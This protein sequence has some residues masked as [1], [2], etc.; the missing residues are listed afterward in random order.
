MSTSE[1]SNG[2]CDS[3]FATV[4]N[5]FEQNFCV[6]QACSDG[7]LDRLSDRVFDRGAA[8]AIFVD[9]KLCVNLWGGFA[10]NLGLCA[11]QENTPVCV[12]S[13]GKAV[14]SLCL[15]RLIDQNLADY[16]DPVCRYWPEF[17][18][19]GKA[20]ITLRQVLAHQAGLPTL[21]Q[22]LPPGGL[23]DWQLVCA[24]LAEETPHWVPGELHGYHVLSFG[25]LLGELIQR[26]SGVTLDIFLQREVLAFSGADFSF[27]YRSQR[28]A[29]AELLM[30]PEG[31]SM[32][33]I[34][35]RANSMSP[36]SI[37]RYDDPHI[38]TAPFANTAQWK[39]ACLPGANGFTTAKSLAQIYAALLTPSKPLLSR[40][41]MCEITKTHSAGVD[42]TLGEFTR[43]GLGFQLTGGTIR[44]SPSG[45]SQSSV[46]ASFGH[47]GI[48]GSVGFADTD[49]NIAFAYTLNQCGEP[50]DH[51]R[52]HR[53]IDALYAAL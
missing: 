51:N 36:L 32:A 23:F 14:L 3:A 38:L 37:T 34:S 16:D 29:A 31:T 46:D 47:Y 7:T 40:E 48:Y 35:R 4:K 8:L 2:Y 45:T 30:P 21:R 19:N 28:P 9:G 39:N 41:R 6:E 13:C 17:A 49:N 1:I 44:F 53:L 10:D 22:N 33:K 43:W 5:A 50:A 20:K 27:G 25:H 15:H 12:F 24:A 26:I 18:A 11:W 52:A 42:Q